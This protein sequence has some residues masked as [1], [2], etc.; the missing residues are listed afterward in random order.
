[1][2]DDFNTVEVIVRPD[3]KGEG[4]VALSPE[5][6]ECVGRGKYRPRAVQ[7]LEDAI[8]YDPRYLRKTKPHLF[9]K[10]AG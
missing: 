8:R 9:T 7:N 3:P 1:M 2:S 10:N 5:Y 6:P 4:F